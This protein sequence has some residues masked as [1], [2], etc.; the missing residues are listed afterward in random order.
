MQT[1]GVN[2]V[3]KI[4]LIAVSG[5]SPHIS[6]MVNKLPLDALG[7]DSLMPRIVFLQFASKAPNK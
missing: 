2:L 4:P 7:L 1:K 3:F 6:H 5:V